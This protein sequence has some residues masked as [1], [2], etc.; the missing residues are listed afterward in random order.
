MG[1]NTHKVSLCKRFVLIIHAE[2]LLHSYI[3]LNFGEALENDNFPAY[4]FEN[5]ISSGLMGHLARL[6]TSPLLL[7]KWFI[8]L[9]GPD[10]YA[11][12]LPLSRVRTLFTENHFQSGT[13]NLKAWPSGKGLKTKHHQINIVWWPNMLILKWVAKR[14]K[15]VWSNY[16]AYFTH[17]RDFNMAKCETSQRLIAIRRFKFKK[18]TAVIIHLDLV[19]LEEDGK[20]ENR[21]GKTRS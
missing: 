8:L 18:S 2:E 6:Q 5:G 19:I 4:C 14:L 1:Q 3:N 10:D 13:R 16:P 12:F 20:I 17:R 11:H 9:A 7:W 21:R 15:Q